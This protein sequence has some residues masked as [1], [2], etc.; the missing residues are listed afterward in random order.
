MTRP[1]ALLSLAILLSMAMAAGAVCQDTLD[2]LTFQPLQN[3]PGAFLYSEAGVKPTSP[4]TLHARFRI[5]SDAGLEDLQGIWL[6]GFSRQ[7]GEPPTALSLVWCEEPSAWFPIWGL[8]LQSDADLFPGTLSVDRGAGFTAGS[9]YLRLQGFI[10]PNKGD[11]VEVLLSYDPSTGRLAM[12]MIDLTEQKLLFSTQLTI[13]PYHSTLYPAVGVKGGEGIVVEHFEVL[14]YWV[15]IGTDWNLLAKVDDNYGQLYTVRITPGYDL[16]LQAGPFTPGLDGYFTLVAAA[17]HDGSEIPLL[18]IPGR[19]RVGDEVATIPFPATMLPFGKIALHFNYIDKTGRVWLLGTKELDVIAANI[20]TVFDSLT[21]GT[22]ELHGRLTIT[23]QDET[24]PEVTLRLYADF[25]KP[26]Q[27]GGDSRLIL[28]QL[29]AGL[30]VNPTAVSFSVPV[31][32]VTGAEAGEVGA[33]A[34]ASL[35]S[36]VFR[37]E[38]DKPVAQTISGSEFQ[39]LWL[40]P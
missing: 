31:E 10:Q 28:E 3:S 34:R 26:G 15:P 8:Q 20:N 12:G 37:V 23:S 33:G 7:P 9:S 38:L 14:P 35:F 6:A 13:K 29:L 32:L 1:V 36:L 4:V 5:R 16:A 22:D 17:D 25:L 2:T 30:S 11:D 27:K 18:E 40:L 39:V 24:V 19:T 21:I